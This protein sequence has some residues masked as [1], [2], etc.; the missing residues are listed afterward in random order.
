[1]SPTQAMLTVA[2][3]GV[4]GGAGRSAAAREL[5]VT[6]GAGLLGGFGLVATRAQPPIAATTTTTHAD[7]RARRCER[8]RRW[9]RLADRLRCRDIALRIG[10]DQRKGGRIRPHHAAVR[11]RRP[12]G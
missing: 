7:S 3:P 6:T 12:P 1:M 8:P 10:P 9:A 2:R 11:L 5:P 4:A